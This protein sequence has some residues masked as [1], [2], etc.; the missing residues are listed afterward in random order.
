MDHTIFLCA[1][2]SYKFLWGTTYTQ[3]KFIIRK[4]IIP[5]LLCC[6]YSSS[7]GLAYV[8]I[9]ITAMRFIIVKYFQLASNKNLS[10]EK[11][12]SS[13]HPPSDPLQRT[14]HPLIPPL[15]STS[16]YS[17]NRANNSL[18]ISLNRST[19]LEIYIHPCK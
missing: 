8:V 18:I 10:L 15:L 13:F 1:P 7:H 4:N 6:Y 3:Y 19:G 12:I 16:K 17:F 11:K 5:S 2:I 9:M 14:P